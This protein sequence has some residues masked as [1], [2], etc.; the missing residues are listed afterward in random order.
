M[1]FAAPI[2]KLKFQ[3]FTRDMQLQKRCV[4]V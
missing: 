1:N 3:T 2:Y 4:N